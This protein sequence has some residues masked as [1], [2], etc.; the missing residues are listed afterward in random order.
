MSANGMPEGVMTAFIVVPKISAAISTLGSGYIVYEVFSCKRRWQESPYHRILLGLSISDILTSFFVFFLGSWMM[1]A[2]G[3]EGPG[4]ISGKGTQATCNFQGFMGQLGIASPLY[5]GALSV[6]LLLLL[7]YNWTPRQMARRLEPWMHGI[8]ILYSLLG[9]SLG[10]ILDFYSPNESGQCANSKGADEGL[11]HDIFDWTF[12]VIPLWLTLGIATASMATVYFTVKNQEDKME[13]RYKFHGLARKREQGRQSLQSK[14]F[15]EESHSQAQTTDTSTSANQRTDVE[16]HQ[17]LQSS[18]LSSSMSALP[19]RQRE[20]ERI[21]LISVLYTV[22]FYLTY[23]LY[24]VYSVINLTMGLQNMSDSG[25]Y[26]LSI[27]ILTFLPL[28]G[29]FNSLVYLF[30]RFQRWKRKRTT[31]LLQEGNN[32]R[33]SFSSTH[34]RFLSVQ[35]KADQCLILESH[36]SA[37]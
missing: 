34:S 10:L 16:S 8:I 21:L 28:Q 17:Q 30:P 12:A 18:I 9:A 32:S 3:I 15:K 5:N 22:S 13:K 35:R 27:T 7:R 20:S 24:T 23:G 2:E 25:L 36:A 6:Y 29:F 4:E 33:V 19:R 14:R 31:R 37:K 1:P 11:A 26:A